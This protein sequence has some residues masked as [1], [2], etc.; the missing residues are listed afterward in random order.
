MEA[1]TCP[2]PQPCSLGSTMGSGIEPATA[3]PGPAASLWHCRQP[4]ELSQHPSSPGPGWERGSPAWGA[5]WQL[6][7][8]DILKMGCAAGA[9]RRPS[10]QFI[11]CSGVLA[12]GQGWAKDPCMHP[13]GRLCLSFPKGGSVLSVIL[14][15]PQ[16]SPCCIIHPVLHPHVWTTLPGHSKSTG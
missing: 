14:Q 8:W 13:F 9:G 1:R 6:G 7:P 12:W 2:F 11:L 16:R 3:I 10:T 15:Q 4:P 5:P